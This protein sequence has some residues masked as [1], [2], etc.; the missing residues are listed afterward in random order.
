MY[1]FGKKIVTLLLTAAMAVSTVTSA[2]A[3]NSPVTGNTVANSTVTAVTTGTDTVA[4]TDVQSTSNTAVITNTVTKNG[5]TYTVNY[6]ASGTIKAKYSK[7]YIILNNTTLV[8]AKIAKS[9]KA[10]KTKKIVISAASGQKLNATQFNKKA[11]K[12]FKGKIVIKKSAMT[13]KQYKKLVKRLR[14]GGFKG[15]IVYKK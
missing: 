2:F 5:K 15:K 9:K 11:F 12:G 7:V 8:K 6:I 14:K 3:I 10:R 1:K 4:V 13:K